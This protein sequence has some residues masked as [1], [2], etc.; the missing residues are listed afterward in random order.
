[1][2]TGFVTTARGDN[3]NL[4]ELIARAK[5]PIG[6]KDAASTRA[7]PNYTPSQTNTPRIRGF[8][9]AAGSPRDGDPHFDETFVP[10]VPKDDP[11]VSSFATDGVAGS[12]ADLTGVRVSK[13]SR[14]AKIK[15]PE[16]AAVEEDT[17]ESLGDLM[18]KLE[19]NKD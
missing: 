18:I 7:T 12:M 4:D 3:L 16:N 1:M 15:A 5:R 17:D 19:G 10:S 11:I 6:L 9:P 8:V 13:T 14:V 2:A